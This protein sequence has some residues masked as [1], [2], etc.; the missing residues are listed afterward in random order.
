MS[1][2]RRKWANGI[3]AILGAL[4]L[5]VAPFYAFRS[6]ERAS[7]IEY[8]G[9]ILDASLRRSGG[10]SFRLGLAI[11]LR[12]L[13]DKG[14]HLETHEINSSWDRQRLRAIQKDLEAAKG[15]TVWIRFLS[16]DRTVAEVTHLNGE[17]IMPIEYVR[18]ASQSTAVGMALAGVLFLALSVFNWMLVVRKRAIHD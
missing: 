17:V 14:A 10:R 4:F 18:A 11:K 5:L 15:E 3:L 6:Y 9:K 2:T 12:V 1:T 8:Q 7:L 16:D 13:Y